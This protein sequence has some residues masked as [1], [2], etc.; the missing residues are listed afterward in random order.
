MKAPLVFPNI[1]NLLDLL[2]A[3]AGK[4]LAI[5]HQRPPQLR[6][7]GCLMMEAND[8][9]SAVTHF[10]ASRAGRPLWAGWKTPAPIT[11][12]TEEAGMRAA[13]VI[14]HREWEWEQMNL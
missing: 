4:L 1:Y 14:R 3:Q 10:E 5:P 6:G 11:D 12:P 8:I 9:H 2:P 7:F 13:G